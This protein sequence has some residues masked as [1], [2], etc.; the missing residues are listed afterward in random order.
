MNKILLV[1]RINPQDYSSTKNKIFF[2]IGGMNIP[3]VEN[4]LIDVLKDSNIVEP[5]DMVLK[6]NGIELNITIQQI[7]TIVKLLCDECFSIYGIYPLYN[8]DK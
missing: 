6:Y 2:M 3:E 4:R 1:N 7:P 5:E 8:P